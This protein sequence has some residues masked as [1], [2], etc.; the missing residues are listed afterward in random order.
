MAF[1]KTDDEYFLRTIPK[2]LSSAFSLKI[3]GGF[4]R[5]RRLGFI[6]RLSFFCQDGRNCNNLLQFCTFAYDKR[7]MK[8]PL[9]YVLS[10]MKMS[11]ILGFSKSRGFVTICYSFNS[12]IYLTYIRLGLNLDKILGFIMK[13]RKTNDLSNVKLVQ[14]Q[15]VSQDGANCI[16]LLLF[17][18]FKLLLA[19]TFYV[20]LTTENEFSYLAHSTKYSIFSVRRLRVSLG[21]LRFILNTLQFL[22]IT[23]VTFYLLF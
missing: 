19:V 3:Q 22:S 6:T 21:L 23:A 4:L 16:K 11:Y 1:G 12:L 8:C 20:C 9:R 17:C 5:M 7:D 2:G 18:P 15:K 13:I 14:P 10:P